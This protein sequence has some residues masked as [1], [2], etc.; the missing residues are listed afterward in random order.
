MKNSITALFP[1]MFLLLLTSCS[2]G[3][4]KDLNESSGLTLLKG[5]VANEYYYI[6]VG[7]V[8]GLFVRT[9]TDYTT[10]AGEGAGA[11]L[12]QMLS[13]GYV[14]QQQEVINYPMLSGTFSGESHWQQSAV[15]PDG[16]R[17]DPLCASAENRY[18]VTMDPDS[19]TFRGTHYLRNGC[20]N[21]KGNGYTSLGNV[22]PNESTVDFTGVVE[23]DGRVQ[24]AEYRQITVLSDQKGLYPSSGFYSEQGPASILKLADWTLVGKSSGRKVG[25]KWYTYSFSAEGQKQLDGM[26]AR[27]GKLKILAVSNLRLVTETEAIGE[28][29]WEATLNDLGKLLT[30]GQPKGT[31]HAAFGK[32]PDGTWFVDRWSTD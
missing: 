18:T 8:A 17:T 2:P 24:V 5:A 11:I 6:P 1:M 25:V 22:G 4:T 21:K 9:R 7:E 31:G 29:S 32:K 23:A 14:S 27:A 12:R 13:T 19:N 28:F 10:F 26:R 15:N 30:N 16:T 20:I 3:T